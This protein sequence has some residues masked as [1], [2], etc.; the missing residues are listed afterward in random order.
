MKNSLRIMENKGFQN[1]VGVGS[2]DLLTEEAI[3]KE[4]AMETKRNMK[5]VRIL[6]GLSILFLMIILI[7]LSN[8]M[9]NHNED[10]DCAYH[11]GGCVISTAPPEGWKCYC[12]YKA[13]HNTTLSTLY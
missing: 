1:T 8:S 13:S 11:P 3:Q 2:Q 7:T 4:N 9:P 10:C 12:Q 5:V 6:G